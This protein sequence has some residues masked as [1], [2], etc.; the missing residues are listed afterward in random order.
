MSADIANW[1][2]VNIVN[3]PQVL[4]S[5]IALIILIVASFLISEKPT[6]KSPFRSRRVWGA[7][8]FVFA[9]FIFLFANIADLAD[10]FTVWATLVL[11]GVAIFSFEES[12]RLR[13]QYKEREERDRKARLLNEIIKW[14]LDVKISMLQGDAQTIMLERKQR[15]DRIFLAISDALLNA[16]LMNLRATENSIQVEKEL[17]DVWQSAFFC[18]QLAVRITGKKPTDEQRKRWGKN[19]LDIV[20]RVDQLEEQGNLTDQEMYD[21][22]KDLLEKVSICLKKLVEVE[23]TL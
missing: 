19:A 11:A 16:E 17:N 14:V 18:S 8:L 22:Q 23:A 6:E 13:E 21:G 5:L 4:Q 12:R 7:L 15:Y 2:Q 3:N 20:A 9:I 10:V 1:L